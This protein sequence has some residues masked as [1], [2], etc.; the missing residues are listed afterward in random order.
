M[1]NGAGNMGTNISIGM[2]DEILN[3]D[4]YSVVS[5]KEKLMP[6]AGFEHPVAA[7]MYPAAEGTNPNRFLGGANIVDRGGTSSVIIDSIASAANRRDRAM[8]D[9]QELRSLLPTVE[10]E[11]EGKIFHIMEA[12]HRCAD[13]SIAI[14]AAFDQKLQA[15]LVAFH[16]GDAAPLARLDV[17][18][19]IG[20]F[21]KSRAKPGEL[22]GMKSARLICSQVVGLGATVASQKNVFSGS[23]GA[24]A[25]NHDLGDAKQEISSSGHGRVPSV[26]RATNKVHVN[27]IIST[28]T[29]SLGGIRLFRCRTKEA[30]WDAPAR[31]QRSPKTSSSSATSSASPS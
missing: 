4:S 22:G 18:S 30:G 29:V 23:M 13:S 12:P 8:L 26:D 5:V 25:I 7:A 10:F 20:G 21:W 27:E 1:S 19:L 3:S 11:V 9:S 16:N 2:F 15:A 14:N 31:R 24:Q 6:A 28:T 17:S